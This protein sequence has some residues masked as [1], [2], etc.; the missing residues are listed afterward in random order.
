MSN[1]DYKSK[2]LIEENGEKREYVNAGRVVTF[3]PLTIKK[4][5]TSKVLVPPGGAK[6][7]P[8]VAPEKWSS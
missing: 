7:A 2:L 1:R 8:E 6:R 3:V 5:H 4:K